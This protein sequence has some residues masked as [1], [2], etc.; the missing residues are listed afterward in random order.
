MDLCYLL[1]NFNCHK[2]E[3]AGCKFQI[4]FD[5]KENDLLS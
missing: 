3:G 4:D 1:I 5:N 2:M